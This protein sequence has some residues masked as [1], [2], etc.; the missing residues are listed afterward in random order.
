MTQYQIVREGY[1]KENG[2]II[3]ERVMY[4]PV[5]KTVA[6]TMLSYCSSDCYIEEV[7]KDDMGDWVK[8]EESDP[9]YL[10][11]ITYI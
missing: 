7:T 2:E 5:P 1:V 8:T 9:I 10:T 11:D 6:M 4:P 3:D